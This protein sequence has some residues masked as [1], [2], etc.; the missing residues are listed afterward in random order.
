M[1]WTT[2]KRRF[3]PQLLVAGTTSGLHP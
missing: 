1:Q 3:L 2:K